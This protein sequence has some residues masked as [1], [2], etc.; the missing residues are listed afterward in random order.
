MQGGQLAAGL[1]V[2]AA[3]AAGLLEVTP[4]VAERLEAASAGALALSGSC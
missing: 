2:T 1:G 3:L 4:A